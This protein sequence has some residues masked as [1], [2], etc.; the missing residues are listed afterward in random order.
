MTTILTN[1]SELLKTSGGIIGTPYLFRDTFNRA[2]G[3]IGNGWTDGHDYNPTYCP[4]GISSNALAAIDPTNNSNAG[5]EPPSQPPYDGIGCIWRETGVTDIQ[6]TITVL[7]QAD[8]WR[9]CTPLLHVTP[10]TERHGV[11]AWLSTFGSLP[12]GFLLVGYIGN[13]AT[14]FGTATHNLAVGS[15]T[16][17]ASPQTFTLRSVGGQIYPFMNGTPIAMTLSQN[18]EGG[19]LGAISSFPVHS[20]LAA[21]TLHGIAVDTHIEG[22]DSVGADGELDSPVVDEVWMSGIV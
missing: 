22:G 19:T 15:F 9:E 7:P 16:R 4:L 8:N 14:L 17:S 5:N 1:G 12:S 20:S 11:G 10:G 2:D 21:S 18:P 6:V 3:A 13:P